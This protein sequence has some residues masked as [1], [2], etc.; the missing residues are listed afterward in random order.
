MSSWQ[1]TCTRREVTQT[2]TVAPAAGT[3]PWHSGT[4]QILFT[5]FF[6]GVTY[7]FLYARTPPK[8]AMH[9]CR[10]AV[11]VTAISCLFG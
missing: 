9:F 10:S 4:S 11:A 2:H 8:N 3:M 1:L 6:C 5:T 7:F